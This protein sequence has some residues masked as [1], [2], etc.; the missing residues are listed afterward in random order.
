MKLYILVTWLE[1]IA[2]ESVV[3][4]FT[5]VVSSV[6]VSV[7]IR[8]EYHN[9]NTTSA[10]LPV[11]I[12]QCLVYHD[13]M[14]GTINFALVS[15]TVPLSG[16]ELAENCSLAPEEDLGDAWFGLFPTVSSDE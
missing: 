8:P 3:D 9:A 7:M 13:S 12:Y 15:G 1:E 14:K 5:F 4:A 2:P 16:L 6:V 10:C 11:E